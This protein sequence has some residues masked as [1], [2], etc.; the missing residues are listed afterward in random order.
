M[1]LFF[2]TYLGRNEK[3]NSATSAK[4][5]RVAYLPAAPTPSVLHRSC[6]VLVPRPCYPSPSP[7][8]DASRT[9][10]LVSIL[11]DCLSLHTIEADWLAVLKEG[12]DSVKVFIYLFN[13]YC[14]QGSS[15]TETDKHTRK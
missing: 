1:T 6:P 5:K 12:I 11:F 10:M 15:L 7:P 9:P 2:H 13:K 4:F 8:I 3:G 14:F